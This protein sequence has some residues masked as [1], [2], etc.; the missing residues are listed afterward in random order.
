MTNE[1]VIVKSDEKI[2]EPIKFWNFETKNWVLTLDEATMLDAN[3]KDCSNRYMVS[4]SY[5]PGPFT[6][7]FDRLT[8]TNIEMNHIAD[9]VWRIKNYYK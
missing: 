3:N 1:Y 2:G 6:V 8:G 9:S 4:E 5:C 7:V